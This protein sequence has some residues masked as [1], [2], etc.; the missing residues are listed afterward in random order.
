[1]KRIAYLPVHP[2]TANQG[3]LSIIQKGKLENTAD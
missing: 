1:M 3:K 2:I